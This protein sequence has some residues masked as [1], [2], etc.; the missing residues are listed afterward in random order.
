MPLFYG[1]TVD[2]LHGLLSTDCSWTGSLPPIRSQ[3]SFKRQRVTVLP[4]TE[5]SNQHAAPA[6]FFIFLSSPKRLVL[7]YQVGPDLHSWKW[8]SVWKSTLYSSFWNGN[9]GRHFVQVTPMRPKI[10]TTTKSCQL[11]IRRNQQ[12]E[13]NILRYCLFICSTIQ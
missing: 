9:I 13:K 8:P 11:D 1:F 3:I 10:V 6:L 7:S 12:G 2:V 4:P 5:L